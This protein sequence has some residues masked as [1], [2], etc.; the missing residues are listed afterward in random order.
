MRKGVMDIPLRASVAQDVNK[1]FMEALST[2]QEKV[3]VRE[4][5]NEL[6]T[7]IIK[8]TGAISVV[9]ILSVRIETCYLLGGSWSYDYRDHNKM[10]REQLRETSFG[11]GR[12]EKQLS[13]KVSRHLRLLYVYDIIK[14]FPVRTDIR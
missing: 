4:L 13:A 7:H 6:T 3:P 8:K 2:F 11:K 12:T 5:F 1:R 9:L 10:L 14:N